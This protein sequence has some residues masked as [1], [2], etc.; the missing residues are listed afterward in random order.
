MATPFERA[1]HARF[2]SPA[3]SE[4]DTLRVPLELGERRLFEFFDA[5]L[6]VDWEIYLQP[7]LNG[8]RPDVVLLNPHVGVAVFEVKDWDLSRYRTVPGR[9][10]LIEGRRRDG[11]RFRKPNP[12]LQLLAYRNEILEIYCASLDAR[13]GL[14]AVTAGLV[15]PFSHAR[16]VD[17]FFR[18]SRA[19]FTRNP[20]ARRQLHV[21]GREAL[22]AGDVSR[23][24]PNV[25]RRGSQVMSPEIADDLRH[26]LLE[27]D[28][29][30]EQRA[31]PLLTRR[32]REIVE[33]P[34]PGGFRRVKGAAGSGKTLALA[35]RAARLE[36][37]GKDVLVVSFNLTLLN[38]LRDAASRFGCDTQRITWLNFHAWCKRTMFELGRDQEYSE[39]FQSDGVL[40]SGLAKAVAAALREDSE[41]LAA[42]YD[43]ILVDE[44]QDFLPE[45]WTALRLAVRPNGEMLLVADRAQDV[46]GRNASWTEQAMIGAGFRG[47]WFKL[48]VSHRMPLRLTQLAR[49]FAEQFLPDPDPSLPEA[50]PQQELDVDACHLRWVQ[51]TPDRLADEVIEAV[52]GMV[53]ASRGNGREGGL[54]FADVVLL[55]NRRAFGRRVVDALSRRGIR[56]THTFAED[57]A[58]QRR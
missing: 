21:F 47:D 42:R 30:A 3:K 39:L 51:T 19:V 38:Y 54:A 49:S 9:R 28:F 57:K 12:L 56:V 45:W 32:Q 48:D 53:L 36:A 58:E 4:L 22:S 29:S 15:F 55:C 6:P 8:L 25:D 40:D 43:A 46:H 24:V 31:E 2:A 1:P 44:G 14:A 52:R 17:A 50:S 5:H 7:H 23:L 37:E 27:P 11:R 35:G 41:G 26:W 10:N 18:D 33:I 34:P 13:A 20:A 16:D